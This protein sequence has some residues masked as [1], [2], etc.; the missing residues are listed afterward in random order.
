MLKL[1]VTTKLAK[2]IS[3][4]TWS[5]LC[6]SVFY[7]GSFSM[8]L[9]KLGHL[10]NT[11]LQDFWYIRV[12]NILTSKSGKSWDKNFGKFTSII[13]LSSNFFIFIWIFQLKENILMMTSA[14]VNCTPCMFIHTSTQAPEGLQ[15]HAKMLFIFISL[16][17]Y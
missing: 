10:I 8:G 3:N 7:T 11:L 6:F 9:E 1:L 14:S 5:D 17:C 12:Q 4:K 15:T 16:G 2:H 13:D